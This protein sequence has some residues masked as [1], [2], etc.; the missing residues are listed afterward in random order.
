MGK[1]S[2]EFLRNLRSGFRPAGKSGRPGV[3]EGPLSTRPGSQPDSGQPS[4]ERRGA[5]AS[6]GPSGR[7]WPPPHSSRD[8]LR[9]R[10]TPGAAAETGPKWLTRLGVRAAVLGLSSGFGGASGAAAQRRLAT[11]RAPERKNEK[12]TRCRVAVGSPKGSS[13]P[14]SAAGRA[15]SRPQ[16]SRGRH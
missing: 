2:E 7:H 6:R 4:S 14:P 16:A 5:G 9:A 13:S 8:R 15:G 12:E 1:K 3:R 11:K 10:F